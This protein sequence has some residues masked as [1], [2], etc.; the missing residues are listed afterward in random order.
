[1]KETEEFSNFMLFTAPV[2]PFLCYFGEWIM[3]Y[4]YQECADAA[5][6]PQLDKFL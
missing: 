5:I 3:T 1:M 2:P 6:F 4:K